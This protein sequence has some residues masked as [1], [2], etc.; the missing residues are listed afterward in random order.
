MFF[1]LLNDFCVYILG[2]DIEL[3][4][5]GKFLVGNIFEQT[6]LVIFGIFGGLY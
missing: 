6:L 4:I 2:I 3:C 5:K 1:Y